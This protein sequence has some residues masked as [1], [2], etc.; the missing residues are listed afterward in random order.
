MNKQNIP[1]VELSGGIS[2]PQIGYGVFQIRDYEECRRCVSEAIACGYRLFDTAAAY[3]NEDAVGDAVAEAIQKGIV[4]REDIFLTTKV[5]LQDFGEEET[6]RAVRKSM[7]NLKTD[8]LDLVLLHQPYGNWQAAWKTLEKLQK[9]GIIRAIG[10]SNFTEQKM[11]ELLRFAGQKPQ[12][13]QIEIHPFYTETGYTEKLKE[14]GIQ[15]EAWGPLN[16]G[17]RGIFQ[18]TVLT[19]IGE[20]YG[21]SAAQIALRW[22]LQSGNVIIPKGTKEK[23][24]RENLDILDFELSP[25]EMAMISA[26]DLG[27]SEIIDFNNPATGRLLMKLKIHD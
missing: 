14:A 6:E 2:M 11:N 19:E 27:H 13:N 10:T 9:E 26:M 12:I 7:R 4:R 1:V 20:R 21:K 15:P 23:H 17:Q 5:W 24:M 16:E 3:F 25:D 8:Y 22:N 18:N